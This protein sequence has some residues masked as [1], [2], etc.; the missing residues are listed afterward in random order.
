MILDKERSVTRSVFSLRKLAL[1]FSFALICTFSSSSKVFANCTPWGLD[2]PDGAS[3]KFYLIPDN[4]P[5]RTWPDNCESYAGYFGCSG[6]SLLNYTPGGNYYQS[7]G[8]TSPTGSMYW[9]PSSISKGQSSTIYSYTTGASSC[10]TSGSFWNSAAGTSNGS[11][12]G[13]ASPVV[14]SKGTY[15]QDA[16]CYNP[17]GGSVYV[18][19]AYLT[20]VGDNCS[21]PWG[22][23][24]DGYSNTAYAAPSAD[25]CSSQG[26][27]CNDGSL[28]GTYSYT[29]CSVNSYSIT[30]NSAGGSAVTTIT[31]AYG[32]SVTPPTAPTRSGYTF[33]GWSPTIASTMPSGGQSLTATWSLNLPT[34][35]TPTLS[36]L[37]NT[38]ATLG[39]NLTS[40]ANITARGTCWNTTPSPVANCV[41]E[42]ATSTGAFTQSRTGLPQGAF[43][44]FRG[45]ATN[46]T[47]TAYSSDS[48]TTTLTTPSLTTPTISSV[49]NTTATFGASITFDG[50]SV[51]TARGTCW[52]TTAAPTANCTVQGATSTGAFTH[53]RTSLPQG[54]L[55][56]YRGYAT[57]AYGTSYSPDGS[58]T[59]LT[60][61]T[62]ITPIISSMGMATATLGA[63]VS[64]NG[65]AVLS[66]RGTCY[67]TNSASTTLGLGV[68]AAEGGTSVSAFTQVKTGLTPGTLYYFQGY[69]TNAYGT[70]YSP[71]GSFTTQS[72]PVFSAPSATSIGSTTA[73]LGATISSN[74]GNTITARGTCWATTA[75][76]LTNCAAE[77]G[78]GAGVYTQARTGFTQFTSYYYRGYVSYTDGSGYASTTYGSDG[79]FTTIAVPTITTPTS[80]S[81]S[82]TTAVLGANITSDGGGV[83]TARGTCFATT[84]SPITNCTPEGATS[85]GVFTQVRTGLPAGTLIY[86]RGYATNPAGTS[87]S[88]DGTFTTLAP[89][90]PVFISSTIPIEAGPAYTSGVAISPDESSVYVAN[91]NSGTISQNSRS[92]T[93]EAIVSLP[94]SSVYYGNHPAAV[95]VSPDGTS[96]Y[97]VSHDGGGATLYS[98]NVT[99]GALTLVGGSGASIPTNTTGVYVSPDNKSVYVFG[100]F[101]SSI[102]QS[103][104]NTSTGVLTG[105]G[106]PTIAT[107]AGAKQIVVAPDGTS[108]YITN[109]SGSGSLGVV[110]QYSRNISTGALTALSPST[111]NTDFDP[112]GIVIS[113]DGAYVYVSNVGDVSGNASIYIYSRNTSTGALTFLKRISSDAYAGSQDMKISVDGTLLYVNFPGLGKIAVY[114]RNTTTGLLSSVPI[115]KYSFNSAGLLVAANETSFISSTK[116]Y[117]LSAA[118]DS[119]YAINVPQALS[120]GT[121]S[122]VLS[123][124]ITS[125]GGSTIT[126]RGTCY[127]TSPS[128]AVNC[129]QDGGVSVGSFVHSRT[130]LTPNTTY[131][132]RAY[133]TNAVGTTYSADGTFVT[134]SIDNPSNVS[135]SAGN[136]QITTSYTNTIDSSLTSVVV[137]KSTSPI[138]NSP[139]NGTSYSVGDVVTGVGQSEYTTPGSYTWVAP[140]GVTKVNVVAVGGG[141][142]GG[143]GSTPDILIGGNGGGL[144]WKN[145]I[146]VIPGNSYT[147]FVGSANQDSYFI[148]TATVKGGG[149]T[150]DNGG[151]YT[152]DGGGFGG[153]GGTMDSTVLFYNPGAGGAG[154]YNGKGGSGGNSYSNTATIYAG[155]NATDGRGGA[156][157][158][159]GSAIY[160]SDNR[161]GGGGGVGIYGQGD[162]GIG[163]AA[164]IVSA[165]QGGGGSNGANG[166]HPAVPYG[167]KGGLYGGGSSNFWSEF[168]PTGGAVRIMWGNGRSFPYTYAYNIATTTVACVDTTVTPGAS[169]SCVTSGLTNST[170]YYFKVFSKNNSGNYSSGVVPAGSPATPNV[171]TVLGNGTNP[172]DSTIAPGGSATFVDSFTL[173]TATTTEVVS[174]MVLALTNASSTSLVEV[175]NDTGSTVYGSVINPTG[176]TTSVTLSNITLTASTVLTQYK[177]RIT[178][179]SQAN[180]PSGV[181]SSLYPVTATVSSWTGAGNTKSGTDSSSATVTIDNLPP[182]LVT[183]DL[184]I[185]G[186]TKATV[187]YTVPGDTDFSTVTI[188]MSTSP[189]TDSPVDGT[190]YTAGNT[191]GA[192]TVACVDSQLVPSAIS[193][194]RITGL[195]NGV[196]YYFKVFTKDS[197]GNYSTGDTPAASPLTPN[198]LSTSVSLVSY[199]LRNDNG[200]ETSATYSS[201]ENT[202]NTSNFILGD[203]TRVRFV[204]ANQTG[205]ATTKSYQVEY[206]TGACTSWTPIPRKL[207]A[208]YQH[209]KIEPSS[210]VADNAVTTHSSGLS[211]PNGKTFVPGR[212]QTFSRTT[213]P[214]TLQSNEYTE[215][216][217]SLRSTGSLQT[218]TNYCFRLTNQGED[219]DF[220]YSQ[221]LQIS[222]LSRLFRF[223]GGGGGG[224]YSLVG[225][226]NGSTATTTSSG[227]GA[228]S[229]QATSTPGGGDAGSTA[230]TTTSTTTPSKGGGGGDVGYLLNSNNLFASLNKSAFGTVL[231]D[232]VSPICLDLKNN[233]S[234]GSV[235]KDTQGE[236]SQLQ[237]YLREQ[238]YLSGKVTGSY[239]SL[240]KNAVEEFQKDNKIHSTG[241]VGKIT[242]SIMKKRSCI[243]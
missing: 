209:W 191:I 29:S 32:T 36:S 104:R 197:Y 232:T 118:S 142:G 128:P 76:P 50:G 99:T 110:S 19:P 64:T 198:I 115:K 151:S 14:Y 15:Y 89:A 132:F 177:I 129:A 42:G 162:D 108:L 152:G 130:G 23:V 144:G 65:G 18:S 243:E 148:D 96:L 140:A 97:A 141:S 33:T 82:Y 235:D 114:Q 227:G 167:N 107:A 171:S 173:Q 24:P 92:T 165:V 7:C 105:L 196:P 135:I 40:G 100:V 217:F 109:S 88:A 126:A 215:V 189:I 192:S 146:T 47:G 120:V 53:A 176:A 91:F 213:Q 241:Y 57:N 223:Y 48:S 119:T 26:R 237:F 44:Y 168:T 200:N 174:A 77:G 178:P 55:I 35:T 9:S 27:Y 183:S 61:P 188:L 17:S 16:S 207:D 204:V 139:V 172:A 93:T 75:A 216:E 214:I 195:T 111:V 137:L 242:R 229:T 153:S 116:A 102:G 170:S 68:C 25:V 179:K 95:T 83:I 67:S 123:S 220:I 231:G 54:A 22:T 180:L 4:N 136:A 37:T 219:S 138:L 74:G 39:A 158:G 6:T 59:T 186:N 224:G 38:T 112:Y 80:A 226:E 187:N 131:Y 181:L 58:T 73:T 210:Y 56:Y 62:L 52:D 211:I 201:S 133:A 5:T 71:Q 43:I 150:A 1:I 208:T 85:T 203:K 230:T 90:A 8:Y 149:A 3:W 194:C 238:G 2:M 49:T 69:A 122:V 199:R 30:F 166:T 157:G 154:G 222:P 228:S 20:V 125:D 84:A 234:Y 155:N 45:Y 21:S 164:F 12:T 63:T 184:I 240:T 202:G 182:A 103:S 34:V 86:Y 60:S 145:S 11:W 72:V 127:G 161:P 205:L 113:S 185:Q 46:A 134:L 124:T 28:S 87:Y 101:S 94:A 147:V 160:G 66:A 79:T 225:L 70:S 121:S 193:S 98:R 117:K 10:N 51:I 221:T 218:D 163:S 169:D 31:Q 190:I 236:V 212:I 143:I 78:T 41:A 13:N 239:V 81:L 159:S 206:A 233:M 106:S 156:G 175:T